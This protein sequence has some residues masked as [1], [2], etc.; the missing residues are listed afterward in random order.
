MNTTRVIGGTAIAALAIVSGT[1]W[2]SCSKDAIHEAVPSTAA[3]ADAGNAKAPL[4]YFCKMNGGSGTFYWDIRY[5]C[6]TGMGRAISGGGLDREVS[7]LNFNAATQV[8]TMEG[9]TRNCGVLVNNAQLDLQG[10]TNPN[11]SCPVSNNWYY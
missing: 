11:P 10:N 5:N 9:N 3:P 7:L 4:A 2:T 6:F 8:L 1:I